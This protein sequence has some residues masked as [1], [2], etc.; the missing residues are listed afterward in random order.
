MY[1]PDNTH[2]VFTWVIYFG[3]KQ[4]FV[5]NSILFLDEWPGFHPDNINRCI[6][7]RTTHTDEGDKISEWETTLQSVTAFYH[8]LRA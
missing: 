3:D 2:F 7:P 4:V 1:P 6:Q 8:S 5:Q